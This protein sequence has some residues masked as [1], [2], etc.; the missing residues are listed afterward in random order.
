MSKIKLYFDAFPS[1]KTLGKATAT[2]LPNSP[3]FLI[4]IL[5]RWKVTFAYKMKCSPNIIIKHSEVT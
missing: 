3:I 5:N 1:K 4:Q 2:T